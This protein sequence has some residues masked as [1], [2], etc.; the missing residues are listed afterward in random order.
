MAGLPLGWEWDYDGQRWFYTYKPTGH[1]Q[2]HFPKEGDEF[3]DFVDAGAPAPSLAP[4]ELLASQQQVKRQTSTGSGT[5]G[6]K[7]RVS[8]T[9]TRPVSSVWEEASGEDAIFQPESLMYLGPGT[10]NDVSPLAEE[11]DEAARRVITGALAEADGTSTSVSKGPSPIASQG[12]TPATKKSNVEPPKTDSAV[13]IVDAGPVIEVQSGT[14]AEQAVPMLDSREMPHEL[15]VEVFNPVGVIAEMASE[16]TQRAQIE[17][18]PPPV[19]IADNSILAPIETVLPPQ[20]YTELPGQT[21]PTENKK[22]PNDPGGISI[23]IPKPKGAGTPPVQIQQQPPPQQQQQHQEPS[24]PQPPLESPSVDKQPEGPSSKYQPFSP[25]NGSTQ[26]TE[27][28]ENTRRSSMALDPRRTSIQREPSLLLG[29]GKND[30]K[31]DP[32]LVPA[33][34]SLSKPTGPSPERSP[35]F[36]PVSGA[37]VESIDVVKPSEN[38]PGIS[39]GP[40]GT[41][42]ARNGDGR[43]LSDSTNITSPLEDE[44]ER[45]MQL[46][47]GDKPG[48]SKVPSV[49]KP[50][51]GRAPSL[52]GKMASNSQNGSRNQSPAQT[53][54]RRSSEQDEAAAKEKKFLPYT[55]ISSGYRMSYVPPPPGPPGQPPQ[56]FGASP[57]PQV[58]PQQPPQIQGVFHQGHGP[59][60]HQPSFPQGAVPPHM[61]N[62]PRPASTPP[63]RKARHE[64]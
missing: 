58:P 9:A 7:A 22:K 42:P 10:Y 19:E 57:P 64:P 32:S 45:T 26:A 20:G 60:Q 34:L 29:L 6:P 11:E 63:L 24:P 13:H 5:G 17:T 1:V 54:P 36:R 18:N 51:R 46:A 3:P 59:I 27:K 23:E 35:P 53:P 28:M 43:K 47:L 55:G 39:P 15:P 30:N 16:L 62:M 49:L 14:E 56:Q 12:A 4:E 61:A 33:A 44:F 21:S 25:A 8:A 2:Y 48:V 38:S 52:P 50:A 37:V 40:S 41:R 31:M